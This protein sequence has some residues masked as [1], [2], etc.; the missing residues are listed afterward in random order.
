M[1]KQTLFVILFSLVISL[2]FSQ[3]TI[4]IACVGNS[5]TYGSGV[6]NREKNAY[7][8]QLQQLLGDSYTVKNYGVSGRTLLKKGDYPYLET[9]KYKEALNFIPDI[10]FIKLGTN[11]SKSHNRIHLDEFE[12]NYNEL[13]NSFKK[14][15][16]KIPELFYY[17]LFQHLQL[18]LLVF[19]IL[20]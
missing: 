13:I 11:D 14:K 17:C 7:P 16:I 4:K 18:I 6:V 19:G 8:A 15:K 5:I 9:N 2:G 1:K 10:V 20:L 12:S 3:K